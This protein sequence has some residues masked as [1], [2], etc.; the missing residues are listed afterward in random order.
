MESL[1]RAYR[2]HIANAR[3]ASS[4]LLHASAHF[5]ACGMSAHLVHSAAH[6]LHASSHTLHIS[7]ANG[8]SYSISATHAPLTDHFPPDCF[9]P[10]R[11]IR[12]SCSEIA[13]PNESSMDWQHAIAAFASTLSSMQQL[14]RVA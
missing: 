11:F 7:L 12:A 9:S 2:L 4:H 10:S 6:C 3:Q 13:L 1:P 14:Q 8:E 5:L